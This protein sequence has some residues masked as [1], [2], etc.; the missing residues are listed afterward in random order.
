MNLSTLYHTR[1]EAFDRVLDALTERSARHF[2]AT[3]AD[4][5]GPKR[6]PHLCEARR[7]ATALARQ[8][9]ATLEQIGGYLGGRHHTTVLHSL[10][11]HENLLQTE[12]AYALLWT[13]IQ[14]EPAAL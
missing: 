9:G 4:V 12:P 7:L 10:T 8:R 11:K 3:L 2:G 13:Q 6:Y 14:R 5:R 1:P